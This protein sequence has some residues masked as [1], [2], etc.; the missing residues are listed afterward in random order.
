MEYWIRRQLI[1]RQLPSG[2]SPVMFQRWCRL[3]FL[4]WAFSPEAVQLT[5]PPGLE[6]DTFDGW[7]WIG[8]VPFFIR[9]VRPAD[10]PL[11]PGVS[12]FLEL[13]LRTYVR[14]EDGR[15]GV[16][17]YSLDANQW[18]AVCVARGCFAL[19]YALAEMRAK[20][21][22]NEIDYRS[23]R[24]GSKDTLH[25]L[26]RPYRKLGEA[27]FGTLEFFLIERYR[28]FALRRN[29][30][31]TGR[32]YHSPYELHKVAVMHADPGLFGLN[33]FEIP[34]APPAH[35]IY[36]DRVDVSVYPVEVIH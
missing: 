32:V 10:F 20:T 33:G 31:V 36:A 35:A 24:Y 14:D 29:G 11:V 1:E 26:Y 5:L 21:S 16:W 28:L 17:F 8:I 25:F 12:N 3:L 27:R 15:P 4:H 34:S 30:L 7:A 9:D 18:L 6:V 23:R 13:N 2:R 19:P 22:E